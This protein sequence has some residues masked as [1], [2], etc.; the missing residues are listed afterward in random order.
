MLQSDQVWKQQEKIDGELFILTYGSFVAQ[1][2]RDN[3]EEPVKVNDLLLE[4]GYNMGVR[5]IDDYLSKTGIQNCMDFKETSQQVK[6]A[7]YIYLG[8]HVKIQQHD[9]KEFSILLDENPLNEF[10]EL[11]DGIRDELWYSNVYCGIIR[12]C[13]EMVHVKVNAVYVQDVLR[14]DGCNEIRVTLLHYMDQQVPLDQD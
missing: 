4:M 6:N 9:G 13:L 12:G 14:G 10:V 8:I 3:N 5:L 1:L 7:F 11:P 2:L